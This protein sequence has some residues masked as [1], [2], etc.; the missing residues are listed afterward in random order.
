MSDP[1]KASS[2][3]DPRARPLRFTL[4]PRAPQPPSLAVYVFCKDKAFNTK[5]GGDEA[6][7]I[8]QCVKLTKRTF[9]MVG[10]R[11]RADRFLLFFQQVQAVHFNPML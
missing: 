6:V 3:M 1:S 10:D 7:R 8:A 4:P 9:A 11:S 5:T 2:L